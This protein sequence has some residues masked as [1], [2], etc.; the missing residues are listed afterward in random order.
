MKTI[1]IAWKDPETRSWYPIGRLDADVP[2]EYYL[3]RYT[4]GA[5]QAQQEVGFQPLDAFPDILG[6][7]ES[8]ELFPLFSNRL[9]NSTRPSFKDYLERMDFTKETPD[10]IELL[11]LSEGR[12]ATDNLEVF[13]QV[14]H[15]VDGGFHMRFFLHG[16]RH[17]HPYAEERMKLLNPGEE[18]QINLEVNNPVSRYAVLLATTDA[19]MLGWVPR[20]LV[21]DFARIIFDGGCSPQAFVVR[22][23]P[24]PAPPSQRLLV[25]F[26]GCWPTDYVPMSGEE[27]K[28]VVEVSERRSEFA[29]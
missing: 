6:A 26:C 7:Y 11:G 9:Q 17:I 19:V 4:H 22:Y 13:P 3:F 18:L 25:E 5:L 29:A 27:F 20:Y 28:P 14:E 16:W 24:A 21:A 12:R 15:G 10:P 23:N 2:G 8:G 1:Y